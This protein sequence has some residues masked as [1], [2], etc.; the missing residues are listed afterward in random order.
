M[1]RVDRID[2]KIVIRYVWEGRHAKATLANI[3]FHGYGEIEFAEPAEAGAM[4]VRG[5]GRFWNVDESS[6]EKTIIK[7]IEVR[8]VWEKEIID[9]MNGFS[10]GRK[11]ARVEKALEEFNN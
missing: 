7:P 9:D 8:R 4:L 2:N 6:P 1:A 10:K 3:K 11:K 5:G